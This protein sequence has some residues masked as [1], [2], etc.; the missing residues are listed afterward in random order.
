M[1]AK[2][3]AEHFIT[4]YK[5]LVRGVKREIAFRL[6]FWCTLQIIMKLFNY[7]IFFKILQIKVNLE[8]LDVKF[9]IWFDLDGPNSLLAPLHS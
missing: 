6:D 4:K 1:A 5:Q 3:C 8:Q 9:C 2:K 7:F